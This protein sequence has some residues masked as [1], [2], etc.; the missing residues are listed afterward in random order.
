MIAYSN[1]LASAA[2]VALPAV[3]G[4]WIAPQLS[5]SL[6]RYFFALTLGGIPFVIGQYSQE[7]EWGPKWVQY[8]LLDIGYAPW[9]TAIAMCLLVM[10]ARL[11][12]KEMRRRTL[13]VGSFSATILAGYV[14]EVWDTAW[15]WYGDGS[16]TLAV[17][18]GDYV[19]ITAGGVATIA[20]YMWFR[21]TPKGVMS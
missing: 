21:R 10:G 18:V 16:F 17:D 11:R 3:G 20:L 12:K 1:A 13:L 9:A 6:Q 5:P 14:T 19:A 15:A 7:D 8:H 2:V 4:R